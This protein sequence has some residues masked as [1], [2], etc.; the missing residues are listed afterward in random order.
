MEF[1]KQY[2]EAKKHLF[3]DESI[4]AAN[5]ELF[6]EFFVFEEWKLKRQNG[7]SELDNSCYKTLYGYVCKLKK[8]NEWFKNKSWKELT[9][10]DIQKVYDDLEDGI[11]KSQRGQ[12]YADTG[13]YYN[14]IFRGKPFQLAGKAEIAKEVLEY[15]KSSDD[16]EVR[17]VTEEEF[18]KLV[19][20]VSNPAH[21][22]LLWLQWDIG[23]NISTLLALTKNDIMRQ[24]NPQTQED[25]YL[26]NLPK[27]KI[28][29]S[30]ITRSEPTLYPETVKYLDMILDGLNDNEKVFSFEHR[31]ALKIIHNA[32]RKSG[33]KCMPLSDAIRWKDLRAGMACHLLKSGWTRD[34]VNAR[35]G[36][37]PSSKT[38]DAYINYL[39][40]DRHGP[41][42]RLFTS[43]LQE[44][45]NDLEEAKRREKL[46][47]DRI[48]RQQEELRAL[49]IKV[50]EVLK[51]QGII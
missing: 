2:E 4:C 34:E 37:S 43:S 40:I 44:V 50:D 39:A 32:C 45:Q 3:A 36:H 30:R 6:Q 24:K 9:K 11:I 8:V 27:A 23:E 28:K 41:K 10:E 15:H 1:K 38:L 17:F 47:A 31:Q 22:A 42:R 46:Q 13:G 49:Q 51:S 5:K 18:R 14:K 12:K 16:K 48:E 29:R 35:L 20:V 7:L 19:S 25:E 33:A 21:L 26:V